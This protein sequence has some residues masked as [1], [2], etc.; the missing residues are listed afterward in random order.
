MSVMILSSWVSGRLADF[1]QPDM[2]MLWLAAKAGR[3][4]LV[5]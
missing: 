2:A 1:C 5:R 4:S 3:T